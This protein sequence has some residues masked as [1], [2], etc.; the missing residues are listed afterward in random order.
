[1]RLHSLLCL[2][3]TERKLYLV[4]NPTVWLNIGL[5]VCLCKC[6]KNVI[7]AIYFSRI[8]RYEKLL[9]FVSSGI[10]VCVCVYKSSFVNT[11]KFAVYVLFLDWFDISFYTINIFRLS[12]SRFSNYIYILKLSL[13]LVC[14]LHSLTLKCDH[15][16]IHAKRPSLKDWVTKLLL[17]ISDCIKRW[18][19]W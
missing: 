9:T 6:V 5:I 18:E 8:V 17:H 3:P 4:H 15:V 10:A 19:L 2:F 7:C 14:N 11:I 13:H 1:L 16:V 12:R